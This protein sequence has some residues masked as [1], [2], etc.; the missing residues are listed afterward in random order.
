MIS[1]VVK[2][3]VFISAIAVN[4]IL[5]PISLVVLD[6]MSMAGVNFLSGL[7]CWMGY[8]MAMIEIEKSKE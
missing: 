5:F 4:T 3:W 2:K 8:Y 7:L 6:S 1:P